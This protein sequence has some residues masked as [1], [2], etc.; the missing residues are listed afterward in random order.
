MSI[1]RENRDIKKGRTY[2]TCTKKKECRAT[3]VTVFNVGAV[4][5][6]KGRQHSH[7]PNW[8][9]VEAG[10]ALANMKRMVT[11]HP[12]FPP[13]QILRTEL[14]KLSEG[15]ISQ[16][17]EREQLKKAMRR[18]RVKDQRSS[19]QSIEELREIPDRKEKTT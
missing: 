8:E 10:K 13:A 17:P 9:E 18:E 1:A 3:A 14:P 6:V 4:Q 15:T 2:W 11:Q 7:A 16:L 19:L 5:V 12:D